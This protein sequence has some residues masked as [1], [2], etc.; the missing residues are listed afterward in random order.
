MV[1]KRKLWDLWCIH[2]QR[3]YLVFRAEDFNTHH[4]LCEFV[5]LDLEMAFYKHYHEV[6]SVMGDCS[7]K[8]FGITYSC[9]TP[10]SG[11]AVKLNMHEVK[12]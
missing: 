4:H 9:Y 10:V 3:C 1:L 7:I 6:S 11:G 5:S 12:Y 8:I 2:S